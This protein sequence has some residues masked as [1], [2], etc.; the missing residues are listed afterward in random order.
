MQN[1]HQYLTEQFGSN[2]LDKTGI[3]QFPEFDIIAV[4]TIVIDKPIT[5]VGM[6]DTISS[7]SLL[8]AKA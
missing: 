8:A 3:A 1:L 2:D 4:P 7:I 6:G 5:L